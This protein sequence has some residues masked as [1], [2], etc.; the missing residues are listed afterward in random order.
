MDNIE[1]EGFKNFDESDKSLEYLKLAQM[2]IMS[3]LARF[4]KFDNTAFVKT[5]DVNKND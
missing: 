4:Y 5:L 3:K 1:P 2:K